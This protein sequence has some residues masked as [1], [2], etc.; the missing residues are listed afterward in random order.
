MK[1][2]TLF[3]FSLLLSTELSAQKLEVLKEDK[4][5]NTKTINTTEEKVI[6][7]GGA[8]ILKA[9]AIRFS[10]DTISECFLALYFKAD[11]TTTIDNQCKVLLK[12]Q[13]GEVIELGYM[14]K[15]EVVGANE[16]LYFPAK[17]N[18]DDLKRIINN[19]VT[20]V[21][22]SMSRYTNDYEVNEKR[23]GVLSA[24]CKL[25]E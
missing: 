14:G 6:T 7:A 11:R 2:Y 23:Q 10:N 5:T 1:K 16:T 4:F 17:L 19:K 13:N 20:D 21:R 18:E 25:I 8:A 3:V 9:R 24:L 15:Y 12:L 22:L